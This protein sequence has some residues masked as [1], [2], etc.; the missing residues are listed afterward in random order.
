MVIVLDLS[1]LNGILS[2]LRAFCT[3]FPVA[4]ATAKLLAVK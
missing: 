4:K 2:D 1:D 3:E